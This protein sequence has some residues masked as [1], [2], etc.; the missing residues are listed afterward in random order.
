M[1]LR[2][3]ELIH[4]SGSSDRKREF[5]IERKR[6]MGWREVFQVEVGPKRISFEKYEDAEMYLM[7]K[8][9]DHGLCTRI[10]STY[11]YEPYTYGY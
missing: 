8:Y 2:I 10:G 1:R 3:V 9:T 4:N 7:Q 6:L 11:I 5:V